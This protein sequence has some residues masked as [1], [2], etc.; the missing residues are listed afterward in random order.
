ME[1][2]LIITLTRHI[3]EL[4]CPCLFRAE[5]W[6]ENSQLLDPPVGVFDD[7][8]ESVVAFLGNSKFEILEKFVTLLFPSGQDQ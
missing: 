2:L 1:E 4:N 7:M 8:Y 5:I 3:A 6:K